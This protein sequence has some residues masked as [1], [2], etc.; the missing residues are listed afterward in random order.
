MTTMK[1]ST[2]SAITV[3]AALL[4]IGGLLRLTTDRRRVEVSLPE[5]LDAP[6]EMPR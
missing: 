6:T 5:A 2:R 3:V 1:L 4:V